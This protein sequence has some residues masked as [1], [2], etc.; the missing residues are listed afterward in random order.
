[1]STVV[2][3]RTP[4]ISGEPF[5]P[6]GTGARADGILGPLLNQCCFIGT[7]AALLFLR[8]PAGGTSLWILEPTPRPFHLRLPVLSAGC[9]YR[10]GDLLFTRPANG[11]GLP[12]CRQR[13]PCVS[14]SGGDATSR[15]LFSLVL[16]H[17]H[18]LRGYG[19]TE[20]LVHSC[21]RH[22]YGHKLIIHAC[23]GYRS[24]PTASGGTAFRLCKESDA[25]PVYSGA[26]LYTGGRTIGR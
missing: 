18:N 24:E 10:G 9:H 26:P 25:L 8:V 13:D 16:S 6:D 11:R 5:Y 3:Q 17:P 2:S 12:V 1:M 19:D 20:E 4:T 15:Q 21:H 14:H 22:F 23:S 7:A